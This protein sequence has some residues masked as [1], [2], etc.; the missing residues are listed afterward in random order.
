M[1]FKLRD[2][3]KISVLYT[4]ATAFPAFLQLF[5][6]PIIEGEG[7]L[8]AFDFSQIT[9]AETISTLVATFIL[10]SMN[11]AISRFYYDAIDTPGKLS[12]L[13]SSILVG[14]LFRGLIIVGLAVIFGNL[15]VSGFTQSELH[16]FSSYGYGAIL[17]GIN[18]SMIITVAAL[19]R[20][21]KR[22]L[23]FIIINLAAAILRAT[24]QL[25]GLFVFELSFTSYINGGAIGGFLVVLIVSVIIFGRSGFVYSRELMKPVFIFATPLFIFELVKWG[26][27]YFDRILL[28]INPEQLGIYDNAQR[29]ALGLSTIIQGL[30]GALQPDFFRFLKDGVEKSLSDLRRLSNFFILQVQFVSIGLILPVIIYIY[31]F[32]ET[33]LVQSGGLITII[34]TQYIVL[35]ACTVFSLPILYSKRTGLFLSVNL[36]V[37]FI[38][39]T[40]NYFLIPLY[41]YYGAIIASYTANIVQL[42]LLII[43]QNKVLPIRW[44]YL[45]IVAVPLLIACFA[46]ASE[47]IKVQFNFNYITASSIFIFVAFGIVLLLY[48]KEAGQFYNKYYKEIVKNH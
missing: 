28:E 5:I 17:T 48:R 10:F 47:I 35:T 18:R 6:L 34:F 14:I 9:I 4:F 39:I 30:Y 1:Q 46:I 37:L 20:N 41:G 25:V 26:V 45:K 3:L 29:F 8:N 43:V 19:Y 21:E 32:F 13:F 7:R 11:S 42:I 40:L 36:S 23:A 33:S 15:I 2:Y 12:R 31:L 44:N 27:S 38:S 24:G 22:V 16:D